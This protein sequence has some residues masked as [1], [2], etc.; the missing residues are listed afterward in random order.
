MTPSTPPAQRRAMNV[1]LKLHATLTDYLPERGRDQRH[2][3]AVELPEGTTVARAI[4]RFG[5]PS[6]LVHLVLVNGVYVAPE[7]RHSMALREGDALAIWPP[8][9]G[10]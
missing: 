6:R 3:V 4:D 2:E 10:G 8:V 9:A 5:L 7:L 1:V